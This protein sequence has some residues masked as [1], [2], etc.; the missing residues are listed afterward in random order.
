MDS[1]DDDD[2]KDLAKKIR[3]RTTLNWIISYD[4]TDFIRK[5]YATCA[6]LPNT[7]QYSLQRKRRVREL[8]IAP[9]Y[10]QTPSNLFG[11]YDLAA[12]SV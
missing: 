6:I 2:H 11:T 3:R 4:D 8:L 5:V 7:L 12:A 9:H 1:Y 10:L